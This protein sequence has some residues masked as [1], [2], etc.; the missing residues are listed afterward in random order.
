MSP[1]KAIDETNLSKLSLQ[2]K[3]MHSTTINNFDK[4]KLSL[5]YLP[6]GLL[7]LIVVFL[8]G[9]D[10]LNID[11]YRQIQKDTFLFLN[12]KLSQFPSLQN[13]LTQLGNALVLFSFLTIFIIHKPKIWECL[14]SASLASA[15]FSFLLKKLFSV[16][17][18]AATF[19]NDSF[20]IIGEK[21][22]ANNSLPSGHS[23]TVFTTLAV[24][25]FGFMPKKLN[26]KILW[27]LTL[28]AL[29]LLVVS[30]RVGVG[31]HYPLDVIIGSIVGYIS[32]L[33]GIFI[34]QKYPIWNWIN[35]KKY[36]PVFVIL[37]L[38]CSVVMI[39]K[40]N[41]DNLVIFYLALISL[42]ISLYILIRTYV[43]K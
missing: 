38:V 36:Y 22:M 25:I 32:G 21:L 3:I 37:F 42:L 30:T 33:T 8:Y 28:V 43:K 6:I 15:L 5:F 2:P 39:N 11:A 19:D 9:N 23:I 35:N 27:C 10:A 24:L 14:I 12:S 26:L 31:A 20:V 17:R 7:I 40:I 41:S 16:P 4:L 34:N 29:G 18:P 1:A 13:N